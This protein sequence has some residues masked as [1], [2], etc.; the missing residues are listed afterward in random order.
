MHLLD[1]NVYILYK[2]QNNLKKRDVLLLYY[3]VFIKIHMFLYVYKFEKV[4]F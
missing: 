2:I 1:K 3:S 4:H